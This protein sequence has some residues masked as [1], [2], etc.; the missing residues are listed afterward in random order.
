MKFT[1]NYGDTEPSIFY[2]LE[3]VPARHSEAKRSLLSVTEV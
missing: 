2:D 3:R 1:T